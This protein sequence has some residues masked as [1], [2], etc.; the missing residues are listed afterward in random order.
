MYS[1]VDGV[2]PMLRIR[3]YFRS[4]FFGKG[5]SGG[6][7]NGPRDGK[8]RAGTIKPLSVSTTLQRIFSDMNAWR[9]TPLAEIKWLEDRNYLVMECR[10]TED[11]LTRKDASDYDW[12]L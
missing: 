5:N 3:D 10:L 1:N 7:R 8:D 4:C 12:P 6:D 9:M 11:G 2:G